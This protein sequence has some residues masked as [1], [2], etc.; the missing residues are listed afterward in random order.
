[1]S[2]QFVSVLAS[3][4]TSMVSRLE[5]AVQAED[6]RS[7]VHLTLFL[8][9]FL[10]ALPVLTR[11]LSVAGQPN[12]T[13][14]T[15]PISEKSWSILLLLTRYYIK[16]FNIPWHTVLLQK[17]VKRYP[18]PNSKKLKKPDPAWCNL[19]KSLYSMIKF[20]WLLGHTVLRNPIELKRK[21][22]LSDQICSVHFIRVNT[23]N[24]VQYSIIKYELVIGRLLNTIQQLYLECKEFTSPRNPLGLV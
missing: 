8:A 24:T 14:Y 9:R 5:Q 19:L 17:L 13:G 20:F 21:K 6:S 22:I 2:D 11:T 12:A 7:R 3:R 10:Q 4:L 18:D 15:I 1:M 16:W 23:L